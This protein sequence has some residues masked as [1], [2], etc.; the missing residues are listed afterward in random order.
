MVS[1]FSWGIAS[2]IFLFVVSIR[3]FPKKFLNLGYV[4]F[5]RIIKMNLLSEVFLSLQQVTETRVFLLIVS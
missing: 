5:N 2:I 4:S 3:L 1:D